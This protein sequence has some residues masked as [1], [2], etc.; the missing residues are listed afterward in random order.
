MARGTATSRKARDRSG[1]PRATISAA[2][3][4]LGGGAGVASRLRP[5]LTL[6]LNLDHGLFRPERLGDLSLSLRIGLHAATW[7]DPDPQLGPRA[8]Q[9]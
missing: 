8:L 6:T 3:I 2:R 7:L 5:G 1:L 9:A 4:C